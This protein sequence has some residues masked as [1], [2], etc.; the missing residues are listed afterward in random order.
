MNKLVLII[1]MVISSLAALCQGRNSI[2]YFDEYA[3]L[4]FFKDS[5]SVLTDGQIEYSEATATISDSNGSLL[6]YTNA[7]QVWNENHQIMQHGDSLHGSLFP[8]GTN[9]N[10][11]GVLIIP[12]PGKEHF[13]YIVYR[14]ARQDTVGLGYSLVDMRLDGGKGAVTLMD[15]LLIGGNLSE[16]LAAT[17]HANGLDWWVATYSH[18]TGDFFVLKFTGD[19]I[20]LTAFPQLGSV[21]GKI[22]ELTFSRQGDKI[23]R[24]NFG[25]IELL[26][27]DRCNG[28]LS[29]LNVI[30]LQGQGHHYGCEFSAN[31]NFLYATTGDSLFQF[32]L[33]GGDMSIPRI[34]I[35][36]NTEFKQGPA[37]PCDTAI[38]WAGL[39]IGPVSKIYVANLYIRS[40]GQCFLF[41]NMRLSVINKPGEPG[42]ACDFQPYSLYLNGRRSI[43]HLPNQPNYDLGPVPAFAADAGEDITIC[44]GDTATLGLDADFPTVMYQWQSANGQWQSAAAN[45]QVCPGATTTYYLIITDTAATYSCAV[46]QDTV[47]VTVLHPDSCATG[48]GPARP[49]ESPVTVRLF[50]NPVEDRLTLVYAAGRRAEMSFELYDILGNRML[51]EA[52]PAGAAKLEISTGRLPAGV[53][54]YRV[55]RNG[56]WVQ[57]GK[58]AKF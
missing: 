22:G 50:P 52:L 26:Q 37:F 11:D 29:I 32:D 28:Q 34:T 40:L 36:G 3:G 53:Y 27:F 54:C 16:S 15:S 56:Q 23:A 21:T 7:E 5:V 46:K 14:M 58:I 38:G 35:A 30:G 44:A 9:T 48:L 20:E 18:V 13:Y 51:Q 55:K 42:L 33:R 45:P 49:T 24:I 8:N 17:K 43:G 2:W 31:S 6:F 41:W 19:S 39:Q 1:A 12:F 47:T 4:M 57:V 25:Q 10:T